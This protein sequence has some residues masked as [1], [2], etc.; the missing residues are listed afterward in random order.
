[1]R[2]FTRTR[3]TGLIV[4]MDHSKG[5]LCVW[6]E[7]IWTCLRTLEKSFLAAQRKS[8]ESDIHGYRTVGL[9]KDDKG[10]DPNAENG[11]FVFSIGNHNGFSGG[12][13]GAH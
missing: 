4:I 13:R 3:V 1:M 5:V 12:I 9:G 11:L 6:L 7:F 10:G 2:P 8:A